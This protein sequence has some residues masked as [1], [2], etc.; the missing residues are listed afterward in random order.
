M[1][2]AI[3]NSRNSGKVIAASNQQHEVY[4]PIFESL[5]GG[6]VT[7]INLE[8]AAGLALR[9]EF[10]NGI[11]FQMAPRAVDDDRSDAE[12]WSLSCSDAYFIM[13]GGRNGAWRKIHKSEPVYGPPPAEVNG[14]PNPYVQ[15]TGYGK[16]G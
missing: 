6:R 7:E 11:H 1:D 16:P 10:D 2:W 13:V 3:I 4:K 12:F 14:K 8:P 9:L 15:K 5:I